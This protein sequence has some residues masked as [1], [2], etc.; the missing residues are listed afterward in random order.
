MHLAQLACLA[1]SCASAIIAAPFST[2]GTHTNAN[3]ELRVPKKSM[4]ASS[5]A[6]NRAVAAAS[7]A[8]RTDAGGAPKSANNGEKRKYGTTVEDVWR[9]YEEDACLKGWDN[10]GVEQLATST[11]CVYASWLA[12]ATRASMAW[13]TN[14]VTDVSR[15]F[16]AVASAVKPLFVGGDRRREDISRTA[17][18]NNRRPRSN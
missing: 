5:R 14:R 3:A 16:D 13:G 10:S 9:D 4:D 18:S 8:Y 2:S 1:I 15:G 11:A 12:H 6:G 7:A 17:N